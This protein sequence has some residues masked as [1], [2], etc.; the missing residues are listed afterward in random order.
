MMDLENTSIDLVS[1]NFNVDA[2]TLCQILQKPATTIIMDQNDTVSFDIFLK[3][4]GFTLI[5]HL[6]IFYFKP[7]GSLILIIKVEN[8]YIQKKYWIH[9]THENINFIQNPKYSDNNSFQSLY[10]DQEQNYNLYPEGI[11]KPFYESF[12]VEKVDIPYLER[13]EIIFKY[14]MA[15]YLMVDLYQKNESHIVVYYD[16][17]SRSFEGIHP[18]CIEFKS[19]E[20]IELEVAH[21]KYNKVLSMFEHKDIFK[22]NDL[23]IKNFHFFF[24]RLSKEEKTLLE[25]L[26]M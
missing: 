2:I 17:F 4:N 21:M 16:D 22:I 12:A 15:K 10:S 18:I 1:V 20:L 9:N 25:M 6:N 26:F 23:T 3:K 24:D 5:K 19:G 7:L 14:D 11:N 8:N 13:V